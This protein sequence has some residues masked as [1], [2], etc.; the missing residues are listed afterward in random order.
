MQKILEFRNKSPEEKQNLLSELKNNRPD[1][2]PVVID[3]VNDS[4]P[5]PDKFKTRY[6]CHPDAIISKLFCLVHKSAG[7]SSYEALILHV[8][9][10]EGK[11]TSLQLCQT[12]AEVYDQYHSSD[13]YLYLYLDR[14]NAFGSN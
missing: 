13:G 2:I 4:V 8:K 3:L 11:Y 12:L 9:N 6:A 14:H 7:A 5:I 1:A 10:K